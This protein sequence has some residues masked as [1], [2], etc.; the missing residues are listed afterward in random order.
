MQVCGKI[1]LHTASNQWWNALLDFSDDV[2][3]RGRSKRRGYRSEHYVLE[4]VGPE[5]EGE[6]TIEQKFRRLRY[7]LEELSS[8]VDEETQSKVE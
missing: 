8:A 7:E 1:V 3:A 4:L 2:V 5:Y 6:E